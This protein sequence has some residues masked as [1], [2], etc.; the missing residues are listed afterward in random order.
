MGWNNPDIPWRELERRLSGRPQA[1]WEQIV[2]GDGGDSPAWSRKR[3]SYHP[4]ELPRAGTSVGYGELHAHSSFSFLDG[5]SAP[6]ELAEEAVRL[7]LE[8]LT[9]TDHDGVYGVVRFAEA[10]E[11]YGLA[12]GFGAELSLDVALPST[13]AER[14]IAARV[15]VPDPPGTHLL[16]LAR[17]PEG[18]ARLSRVIGTAHLRGG[19]KGRPV[20]DDLDTL[21]EAAD[22]HWLVL[23]GCRKGAVRHAL[24][25]DGIDGARAALHGLVER[26]GRDNVVVELTYDL[27]PLADER[28]EVLAAL[29]DELRL[30]LVATTAAHYHGPPRRPLATAMAAVRARSSLDEMDGWLPAWS[31]QH[32]RSGDEMA[33][34]FTRWPQAVAN[35]ARLAKEI[36]FP[37]SLIAPNLPPF[38]CPPGH[39]EMSYLRELAYEGARERFGGKPHEAKA[40]AMI[41]HELEIIEELHFPGYFLVV[42]E[43]AKFCRDNGI[44]C[45]G[46]GSAAN[47]AV[48]YALR[49]TAIDAVYYDLMFERFLAPERGEPP[50]IDI[51]IES[52]RREEVIQHVYE[53]HGREHAAQVAN[54]ITYRPKSAVRDVAKALGYSQGQQDAWSKEIEQGYYWSSEGDHAGS[55]PQGDHERDE[56]SREEPPGRASAS[57]LAG[58]ANGRDSKIE[59]D[60][61]GA[62]GRDRYSIPAKVMRLAAELQNAPR[63]LGIHSGGMVM[64]DRPVIEVC[65]VEWGRMPGRTVLQWDKDDCAEIGLVKFDLL[66]LGMLSAIQYCFELITKHHGITYELA[67]IPQEAPC[68]Y[69][70]LCEADS[71]GVFQVESRAQMATL[72][73]LKPRNF[74]DL[75]CEVALIRPGPIQG[76]S[77]HPFIRRKNGEEPI[78]YPHPRLEE[79]LKRTLGIPLFQEQL[80]QIAV[81]VADFSPAE[82][83]QLRRAMGSKR[84][85][86]RIEAMRIRLYDGMAANSITGRTADSI[87]E[88]I[89]AF[90]AFGFA[91]SHSISFALLVYASSW[92]KRH[93]P[94]A[95]CAALLNA[96]P[97][98]FYSPQSLIHDAKRHGIE[99]RKPSL[100]VS[101]GKASLEPGSGPSPS[102]IAGSQAPPCDIAGSQAPPCS[103]LDAPQP[104]VRLGLSS[105]RTIGDELATTIVESRD[106]DGPFTS[107]ADLARRVGLSADQVEALATSGAFDIFGGSRRDALWGAGAAATARPGQLDIAT[108]DETNTPAMA[109]MTAPEQL[110]ADMWAT[111][112][113][114]DV[115]PTEL[116]RPRLA[117]LGIVTA[118][119]LRAIEN[120]TRVTIGG[121]VTHR[122]R[123]AT[124]RGVTFLNIEDETGMVNVI[125][126]ETVW[127]R[128]RRVARES[129]GLLIRGMLEHTSDGVIN[130]VAERLERLHLGLHVRSRDFR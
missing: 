97:M 50:D 32:L 123:P 4:A 71:V 38:P 60:P 83:D 106:A 10:A 75:A 12:T 127:Q 58:A 93:Y 129:G 128:H 87:Y 42:W 65:P 99:I 103:C 34:R 22:G 121:V 15:G 94:A 125:V 25:S 92:L 73:R 20:Y 39:D 79:P 2:A 37:L 47:S 30:D 70:M 84:S 21:A 80:M 130:V 114:P 104:A 46:R 17:D 69:D 115:Y 86:D 122:Q 126:E 66:G 76:D 98:G 88:K 91:E 56:R 64:C 63:H 41:E 5:A 57:E 31:G 112:M 23:T 29:A 116:I 19:A 90:A 9:L 108:F 119:D 59:I 109:E 120:H 11:S 35:A 113:T 51:D 105:V 101:L 14:S 74:Y 33:A 44:L 16:A 45:Q 52:D 24:D 1:P 89:Q 62:S 81:A 117:A 95:F 118:R 82:A 27:D 124:A 13:Q 77:V 54:V 53:M 8:S 85:R 111:S 43:I 28:Y 107:M 72:P 67:T 110:I 48:C 6:E 61:S 49:I 78:S 7:G 36:A 40:H 68:V 55:R 96:Q 3:P 100:A 18:Y 102:D 26:F